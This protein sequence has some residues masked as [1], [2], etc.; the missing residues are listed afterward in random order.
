MHQ[1][2]GLI[3]TA[4]FEIQN[5]K[6]VIS[7]VVKNNLTIEYTPKIKKDKNLFYLY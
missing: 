5:D 6:K 7:K 3:K 1:F 2:S 4:P